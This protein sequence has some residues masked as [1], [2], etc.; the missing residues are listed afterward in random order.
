MLPNGLEY[1]ASS[2][3]IKRLGAIEVAVNCDFRGAVL[4]RVLN[5]SPEAVLITA[6]EFADRLDP[7]ASDVSSLKAVVVVGDVHAFANFAAHKAPVMQLAELASTGTDKDPSVAVADLDIGVVVFTSGT[8]GPSKGCMIPHRCMVRSAEAIVDALGLT[9]DDIFFTAY[10]LFHMRA[11]VLDVLSAMLVGGSVVVAPRFSASQFW[12]DMRRF[13]VTVFSIIGTVMQI[14]W[15]Q[16]PS[17][18]DRD[19]RVRISWGG[20]ITVDPV[21]FKRRFGVHV[22]PGEGVFGMSET[23][24]VSMSHHA[25]PDHA[26]VRSVFE[27]RIADDHDDEVPAGDQGEILVRPKEPGVMFAGYLAMPDATVAAWRNLWFHTGDRGFIDGNGRLVFVGRKR[28]TIR[29][30][31]HNISC[32]ELEQVLDAHPGVQES[33][34]IGIPSELGEED[35]KAF[36]VRRSASTLTVADLLNYCRDKMAAYMVPKYIAFI[37]EIPK[38]ETGKPA[39]AQLASACAQSGNPG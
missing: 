32:W 34:V 15:K 17:E 16:A 24:M 11:A 2:Y 22:L 25:S 10:P 26:K 37:D 3:A 35:V 29:K 4:A 7:I 39:K 12:A 8:T 23:G 30:A 36:V 1:L 19:H 5:L 21:D 31:G 6:S 18:R 14:L 9:Q 33:A 28:D 20:P 27:I 13:D 38:T